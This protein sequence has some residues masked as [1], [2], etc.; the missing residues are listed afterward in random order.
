MFHKNITTGDNHFLQ[1]WQVA[2]S[3]ARV[4]LSTTLG[5]NDI[6][7]VAFQQDNSAFYVLQA[8]TTGSN[9]TWQELGGGGAVGGVAISGGTNLRTSG[10]VNFSNSNGVTFGLATN[11]VMTASVAPAGALS[12]SAGTNSRSTGSILF[13]DANGVSFGM[14]TAGVLT[15]SVEAGQL[16][17]SAG[18]NSRNTGTILFNN[19]NGVSFGM[20]ATGG[21]TG[22]VGIQSIRV[23]AGG[24]SGSLTRLSFDDANGVSFGLNGG[25]VTASVVGGGGGAAGTISA[26][27]NSTTLG[28]VDFI[29]ANNVQFGLNGIGQ[30]TASAIAP[31]TGFTSAGVNVGLSATLNS[32]GL[33]LSAT[34]PAGGAGG[35]AQVIA[36]TQ[37]K[38]SG[39]LSFANSNGITFGMSG[40]NTITASY[41][42]PSTAGLLSAINVSGGTTSN[43][44]S[45]ITFSNSNNVSFGLNGSVLTGSASFNQTVQTQNSVQVQGSSGNI[46]FSNSNGITFGFNASTITAS[47]NGITSQSNQAVSA[48]N[49]SSTFQTL[50]F[51]NLN[52]IS[53]GT[54]AGGITASHNALTTARAS[55]DG[56][57]LATAVS[58]VTA[59]INSAGISLDGRNYAGTASSFNGTNISG[60]ITNNSNGLSLAL[61][62]NNAGAA[63]AAAISI[64]GNST[65][66]GAGYSNI[67]SGTAV[68]FGGNNITL[69]QN[70][71][72]ITLSG[73]NVGGA[74]TGISGI[75]VSNTTYTS[76]TVSF[77]DGNGVS[78]GS[79]AGQGLSITHGLQF[80][81]NTSAITSNAFNTS[82]SSNFVLTANSSLLQATS[83]TSNITSNA[84][85]SSASRVFNIVAATNNTGGGAASLSSN[86]S[87]TNANGATFYTSAGG[88]IALSYTAPTQTVQTQNMVSVNGSTGN[89]SLQNGNNVTFGFNASTVTASASFNQ[90]IQTQNSVLVG[91]S[92][93]AITFGNANGITFGGNASTITASHNGLTTAAQSNHSHGNPTLFLTNLS[94]TT[95]SNSAGLT[96]SLSAAAGGGGGA[97]SLSAGTTSS[98]LNSL[99]FSNSNGVSFGLNGSTITASAA[100]GGGGAVTFSAGTTSG[101][102]NSL[103][104]SNSNNLVFGLD[105]ST[106]TASLTAPGGGIAAGTQTAISGTVVF[107]NSNNVTFGMSNNSVITVSVNAVGGGV[108]NNFYENTPL[109]GSTATQT[110]N[111]LN[112]STGSVRLIPIPMYNNVSM[113][114]IGFYAQNTLV[115]TAVAAS[116]TVSLLFGIYN[117]ALSQLSSGSVSYALSQS[118]VS[119]TARWFIS[120]NTLNTTSGTWSG[121]AQANSLFG[122]V[123][124]RRHMLN[125]GANNIAPGMYV[126]GILQRGSSVG[127]NAGINFNVYGFPTAPFLSV[128]DMGD[129]ATAFST[130]ALSYMKGF[131]AFNGVVTV[132]QTSLPATFSASQINVSA[133]QLPYVMLRT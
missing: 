128:G 10:T 49:G 83:A 99:V 110:L 9:F 43:N 38:T 77:I 30:I 6:G 117:S 121:T 33:S 103:V 120:G 113:N 115:T 90:T 75:I 55:N 35:I 79:G 41:T 72:S 98:A 73:A 27:A 114:S 131:N 34:A 106:I 97:L 127:G 58:N 51:S 7:K 15:A 25:T 18:T 126:L 111:A 82:G 87:F 14:N 44:L 100:G 42:V 65:S 46:S 32:A 109:V 50:S 107:S 21:L 95:A 91:G 3:A 23:D 59:T 8:S 94:G 108:T 68:F 123:G 56:V 116:Q 133:S 16:A 102:L 31:G 62:V 48:A 78:F 5:S 60:S 36:G 26:G 96:L 22:S 71:A 80:T 61:S 125:L 63:N 119:G 124:V 76:G 84:L 19:S 64:G 20:N 130:S 129:N 37:S 12:V 39:T 70:G 45:A 104:F 122:T 57:G 11:G 101:A 74:Q 105:G 86:V 4:A 53:F 81:S 66:A 17:L 112:V 118:G 40:S 47:H 67:T 13:D 89:I 29:N 69:S 85:H 54:A 88:A 93:G 1:N 2:D 28:Q 92:S 52:G 24:V 132:T